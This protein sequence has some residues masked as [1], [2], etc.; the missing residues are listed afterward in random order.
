[1][2]LLEIPAYAGFAEGR[3]DVAYAG[4][5][6]QHGR[7]GSEQLKKCVRIFPHK[8]AG[9]G[10]FLALL[11]KKDAAGKSGDA[12]D[13][14]CGIRPEQRKAEGVKQKRI[15][16]G[17]VA[18]S[19]AD[20]RL[21]KPERAALEEFF[22]EVSMPIDW[23]NVE[24]RKG[25]VYCV[26]RELGGRMGIPFLRNGLYLGEIRKERFEPSQSFAMALRREEYSSVVDFCAADERV[27]KY[28]KG[29]T[30]E[31]DDILTARSKGWQLVCVCGYPLGW[32]KLVNGTLKNK[33]HAGWRA[34]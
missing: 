28:L 9:E 7:C 31:I 32:G 6:H 18:G 33:Y 12:P 5:E 16:L 29:E 14:L 15:P 23:R 34:K 1:M 17:S 10:H 21:P 4:W 30:L 22:K 27:M 20:I 19:L 11:R 2:E 3:P 24:V 26:P 8:M 25:Q 13:N